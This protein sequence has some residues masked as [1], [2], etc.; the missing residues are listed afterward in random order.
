MS[1]SILI[2]NQIIYNSYRSEL[3]RLD[4]PENK[5]LLTSPANNC[6]SIIICHGYE[7]TTREELFYEVW[8]K[9]NIPINTNTFYQ[10]ISLIRKA[11]RQLGV[12]KEVLVTIPR[13]GISI[14][15]DVTI[16]SYLDN[17]VIDI[18][19]IENKIEKNT[20]VDIHKQRP[21]IKSVKAPLW[22]FLI[23]VSIFF[24]SAG[25]Y[26]LISKN[27]YLF[28]ALSDYKMSGKLMGCL[29]YLKNDAP[30]L[31]REKIDNE[32]KSIGISCNENERV[33]YDDLNT[34][35]R[36][37]LLICSETKEK[38]EFCRSIYIINMEINP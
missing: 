12:S 13:K 2:D 14:S 15:S 8:T 3:F 4:M 9:F 25:L 18:P 27:E 17:P 28:D 7:I 36:K 11:L 34:L 5:V 33:Y 35:A 32:I 19:V 38:K 37:S 29:F 10:N 31:S 22:T 23:A 6:L 1:N 21:S 16:S 26:H 30:Y 24:I 20:V